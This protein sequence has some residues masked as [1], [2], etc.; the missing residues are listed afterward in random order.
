MSGKDRAQAHYKGEREDA[1]E[2]PRGDIPSRKAAREPYIIGIGLVVATGPAVPDLELGSLLRDAHCIV[3]AAFH[4]LRLD[5]LRGRDEII[6]LDL[7]TSAARKRTRATRYART[8]LAIAVDTDGL[9]M[10]KPVLVCRALTVATRAATFLATL[11]TAAASGRVE[12]LGDQTGHVTENADE[13]FATGAIQHVA[14][15]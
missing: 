13:A 2:D 10:L 3:A 15:S 5:F 14:A 4:Y 6:D 12:R 9:A 11:R 8:T 7:C 1:K